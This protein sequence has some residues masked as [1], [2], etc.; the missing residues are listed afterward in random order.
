MMTR[1]CTNVAAVT[2]L[3]G[4]EKMLKFQA[5]VGYELFVGVLASFSASSFST[6]PIWTES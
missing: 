4:A 1:L 3:I 6:W 5:P 2:G